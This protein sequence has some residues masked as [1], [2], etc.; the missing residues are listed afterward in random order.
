VYLAKGEKK[1]RTLL[2]IGLVLL[3]AAAGGARP[4]PALAVANSTGQITVD[5][6]SVRVNL[7]YDVDRNNTGTG[8]ERHAYVVTD[9]AGSVLFKQDFLDAVPAHFRDQFTQAYT[10]APKFN[11]ISVVHVSYA[12][13]GFPEQVTYSS[14]GSCAGL[15][16]YGSTGPAAIPSTAVVG[17]FVKTT[18]VYS[19]P[20]PGAQINVTMAVGKS[21]WVF[22]VDPTGRFYRVMLGGSLFWVPVDTM[23]P[24]Y[25]EVW[26]GRPLPGRAVVSTGTVGSHAVAVTTTT[27]TS[28]GT[29]TVVPGNFPVNSTPVNASTYT[30]QAGDNLFRIALH[31]GVSLSKLASVNGI[32]DPS[33]IYVGQVLNIAAAR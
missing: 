32:S 11:P 13:N 18:P 17:K 23:G 2:I 27:T 9:G 28:G 20:I 24:N 15:P 22:G 19:D 25:D 16:S 29:T 8:R 1:M 6:V 7:T 5:C 14:S 21:A 31:F 10:T 3:L 33:R 26:Q 4:H 12:G 30:V